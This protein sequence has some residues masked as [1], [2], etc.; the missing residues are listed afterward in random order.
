MRTTGSAGNRDRND[1]AHFE[2][3][4]ASRDRRLHHN[5]DVHV[6]LVAAK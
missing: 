1:D 2:A 5:V 6:P 3:F 4:D